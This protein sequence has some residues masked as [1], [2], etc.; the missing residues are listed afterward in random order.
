VAAL[1]AVCVQTVDQA[2]KRLDFVRVVL[3]DHVRHAGVGPGLGRRR[4]VRW[5]PVTQSCPKK[6]RELTE[7]APADFERDG[8]LNTA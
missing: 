1:V 8:C 4:D 3:T 7:I 5:R 6:A 2:L